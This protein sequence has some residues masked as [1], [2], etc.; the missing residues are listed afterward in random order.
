MACSQNK[1]KKVNKKLKKFEHVVFKETGVTCKYQST[2]ACIKD[3]FIS[4]ESRMIII[5]SLDLVNPLL[6][7][8]IEYLPMN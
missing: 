2:K 4:A 6:L 3:S 1:I 8:E 5:N 7:N